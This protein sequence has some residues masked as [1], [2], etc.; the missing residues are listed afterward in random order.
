MQRQWNIR[1]AQAVPQPARIC[2][3]TFWRDVFQAVRM[4]ANAKLIRRTIWQRKGD[5]YRRKR[6]EVGDPSN[7]VLET[8][9]VLNTVL[10][11][12]MVWS[13]VIVSA[14]KGRICAACIMRVR[15]QMQRR[16]AMNAKIQTRWSIRNVGAAIKRAMIRNLCALRSVF[17]S[18]NANRPFRYIRQSKGSASHWRS[19]LW[20][21]QWLVR[22]SCN[23]KVCASDVTKMIIFVIQ[24][25]C[26]HECVVVLSVSQ[27]FFF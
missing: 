8:R 22:V 9:R 20:K 13:V 17:Q 3:T 26:L 5:V 25:L 16:F 1:N 15:L 18:V 12:L 21:L 7:R 4:R 23:L 6:V 11:T 27:S 2:W 24:F 10:I 14:I 19:V